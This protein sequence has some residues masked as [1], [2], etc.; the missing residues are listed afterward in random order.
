MFKQQHPTKAVSVLLDGRPS[1]LPG[2][3]SVAAAL[4]ATGEIVSRLSPSSGKPCSPHCLMGICYECLMEIDG[5]QRQACMTEVQE[6]MVINRNIVKNKED[7][8]EHAA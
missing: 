1:S 4:L 5:Y 7:Q 6:G 3:M 2:G 8:H